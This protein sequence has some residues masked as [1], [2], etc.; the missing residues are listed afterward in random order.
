MCRICF[1]LLFGILTSVG[2]SDLA[3]FRKVDIPDISYQSIHNIGTDPL[4]YLWIST[5]RGLL[6][7]DGHQSIPIERFISPLADQTDRPVRTFII[8]ENLLFFTRGI[9]LVQVN[10]ADFSYS[11]VF[12]SLEKTDVF[13][14]WFAQTRL[15]MFWHD[16]LLYY[17][18]PDFPTHKPVLIPNPNGSEIQ[19]V[20]NLAG[21]IGMAI[22]DND[23]ARFFKF[24]VNAGGRQEYTILSFEKLPSEGINHTFYEKNSFWYETKEGLYLAKLTKELK[25]DRPVKVL[26][27]KTASQYLGKFQHH[28]ALA[29][30]SKIQLIS[31]DGQAIRELKYRLSG[32][33]PH[34]YINIQLIVHT[35][36]GL[37]WAR[38]P[39]GFF[40]YDP[41]LINFDINQISSTLYMNT[42]P[43]RFV[44]ADK[45]NNVWLS[46]AE[47]GL[48][49]VSA[50]KG[51]IHKFVT[52]NS[53][54]LINNTALSF[55]Q[56]SDNILWM[57]GIELSRFSDNFMQ[58]DY[59]QPMA[60]DPSSLCGW[61]IWDIIESR[62][63]S[64]W[65][66]TNEGLNRYNKNTNDF[67]RYKHDKTDPTSLINDQVW[68]LT[69]DTSGCI[70]VGTIKGVCYLNPRIGIFTDLSRKLKDKTNINLFNVKTIYQDKVFYDIWLTTEGGGLYRYN[71]AKNSLLNFTTQHGLPSNAL[72]KM[73]EDSAHTLWIT[74]SNGL[75]H[76]NPR[77]NSVIRNY[78]VTDGLPSNQ[79]WAHSICQNQ[80]GT[81]YL[82]T[83]NTITSFNPTK[84]KKNP[85]PPRVVINRYSI[86][87]IEYLYSEA[88]PIIVKGNENAV[89]F[90]F[91]SIHY[92]SPDHNKIM[93]R[94]E[95]PQ[96]HSWQSLPS[97]GELV[98]QKLV[99]GKYRLVAKGCNADQV[100]DTNPTLFEFEVKPDITLPI[101]IIIMVLLGS[102]AFYFYRHPITRKGK[103]MVDQLKPKNQK[104]ISS[105]GQLDEYAEVLKQFM[106]KSRAYCNQGLSIQD[107]AEQIGMS[108]HTLSQVMNSKIQKNFYDFVNYYRVEECKRLILDPENKHLK[109]Q[110]IGENCGFSSKSSFYQVFRKFTGM[111]PSEFR[112]LHHSKA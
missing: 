60:D 97:S 40:V 73:V 43:A 34:E 17:Y 104:P 36:D 8:A 13:F 75:C 45:R 61:V 84:L 4:G 22:L 68:S 11:T 27:T 66:A 42:N 80:E 15:L 41:Y 58:L 3:I 59:Y 46:V 24:T 35:F 111:T 62:D 2:A 26:S 98:Y 110:V 78:S 14:T 83:L 71:I 94:C 52:D 53:H 31:E 85:I 88:K 67:L 101:T 20:Y 44:Y 105:D 108:R 77:D 55:L 48:F 23:T 102:M 107:L 6:R 21:N 92:S 91:S 10:L 72:W 7:Y 70:W 9:S 74:T 82:G 18:R 106:E 29:T 49:K 81:I 79:F 47:E 30:G 100:W 93:I 76:F 16:S 65:V 64:I 87:N 39:Q 19:Q 37:V 90:Q 57:G 96:S 32:N 28:I 99:P 112:K 69:E 86:D 56:A 25:F 109:I 54:F 1:L 33:Q 38:T 51:K 12:S 5:S 50:D 89:K 95:G 103:E 63:K